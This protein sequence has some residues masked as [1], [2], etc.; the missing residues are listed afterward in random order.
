MVER[1]DTIVIGAGLGGLAAGVE[2]AGRGQKVVVLEQHT[3]PGGYASCFQRGPYRF[4]AALHALSGLAPGGGFDRVLQE[5]GIADRL[6]L[7][8]LD[9]LYV[10][11]LPDRE[12]VAHADLFRYESEL[13][14]HFPDQARGIRS[15]LDEALAVYH[16]MRRMME[17]QST[18]RMPT[19]EDFPTTYPALVRVSG[20]TWEQMT[21]RHVAD[22]RARAVL[23]AQWSYRGLPPSQLD[24]T[25]AAAGTG[26]YH[27]HGAWYPEGGAQAVSDAL[28]EVL[29]ERGGEIRYGELVTRI[30]VMGRR[31]VAAV[32]RD[33]RVEA[34]QFI[35]NASAPATL[36][37]LVGVDRL[38]S[39]Y[40][41]RVARPTPSFTTVEVSL[42]LDQDLFAEQH[43]PHEL[44]LATSYDHDAAWAASRFGD[45][46][47][48]GLALTDYTRADPGCA[49]PGHAVVVLCGILSWDYQDT[50]G[51]GGDLTDYPNNP[52]YLHVKNDVADRLVARAEHAVP[53]LAAAI[54]HR[55]IT[56]PLTKHRY[57]RNPRGAIL[58]YEHSPANSGLPQQTPISNLLLAGAWTGFGG[59][60]SAMASGLTAGQMATQPSPV[61]A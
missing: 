34:E 14:S 60:T 2:L 35:S 51:T 57:T 27:E 10:L 61:R 32:T 52:R 48:I 13:I 4:D 44:L 30:E 50:W 46:D 39:D 16:Q 45:V 15:Y 11:R 47:H 42:G 56:T 23:G 9:P 43:L 37:E 20:Q 3:G 5:L 24:A 1:F 8:R 53:G 7:N 55:E 28:A 19:P 6:R 59:M 12:V 29:V 38:P 33:E 36:L 26:S 21:A 54:R 25:M 40:V 49:P 58:G 17:D 18:G 41:T 22:P 31:A